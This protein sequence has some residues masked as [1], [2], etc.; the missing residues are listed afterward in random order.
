MNMTPRAVLLKTG[1]TP[2]NTVRPVNTAHPKPAVHSA[3]SMSHFSKQAQSTDQRPFY[4]KT[5]LTSR[6]VNQ[7]LNTAMRHYH[8]ERPRAVNTARSYTA[9]VNAVRA[10]R[11]NVVKTSACWVWRPTRPNG[12]SL[13]KPQKDD[14]GFIDSGCSR[15]MTGNIAYLL[16]FKEFDGGYVTFGG[17]AH[18]GRISGKGTLK[19]NSLD[20]EDVYFVNE[21]NFN[22]F[23]V[24]QM[25]DKKNY[26]LFTNTECLV[27]SPNFKLPDESQIL[28][29]IPRK[30]NMYSF[31]IKNIVP[32]ESL[33]CLVAKA[34]LDESMLWHRRLGHINFKNI[35][36]LVKDNLV[37]GLLTKHF[38]NDQTCVACL[39]GKQDRASC[40]SKFWRTASIR[41]LNN[42][43]IEIN[44]TVDGQDKTIIEAFVRRHL[45]L[46][47]VDGIS[48]LLTTE[49]F[50]QLALMGFGNCGF[51]LMGRGIGTKGSSGNNKG[52]RQEEGIDYKE[53]FAPVARIEA[54]RLFLAYASF[55]GFLDLKIDHPTNFTRW[56]KHFMGCIKLNEHG[57]MLVLMYSIA[58]RPDIM[59]ACKKQTVVALFNESE[60]V[61]AP[62]VAYD[63]LTKG[64]NAGR[65]QYLVLSIRMLN[66]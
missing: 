10:K 25:C 49:I 43:E 59:F 28:L 27:L 61:V 13:D 66:P 18:G 12:A 22:L 16:D 2:L 32:K 29:K 6:Y 63:L 5:T 50:E 20:F 65:F 31:D 58:S 45:K 38:E 56:S 51:G 30:D 23:S 47:D 46:V 41:T 35:N 36:K 17:G 55:M 57:S 62:L 64:F 21:L 33:T 4:K 8:T 54:I 19:T 53:V 40:K 1:L 37:R 11:V 9:P 42:G 7:K 14:I 3:K 52:H 34:T 48:T 60:Y 26:V 15:H 24:S 39:K 44:A